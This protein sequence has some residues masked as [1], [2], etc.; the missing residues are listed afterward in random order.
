MQ[1]K[2]CDAV[3]M[4]IRIDAPTLF[5]VRMPLT[6][7]KASDTSH[8]DKIRIV[9]KAKVDMTCA[10]TAVLERQIVQANIPAQPSCLP[11]A[12]LRYVSRQPQTTSLDDWPASRHVTGTDYVCHTL[13]SCKLTPEPIRRADPSSL[14]HPGCGDRPVPFEWPGY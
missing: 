13:R 5:D 6:L 4:V 3:G 12:S 2:G 9:K 11:S 8:R 7:D 10:S 14:K 1:S